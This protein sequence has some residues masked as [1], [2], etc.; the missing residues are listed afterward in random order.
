MCKQIIIIIII[1]NFQV[2]FSFI[3][4]F[5]RIFT[6]DQEWGKVVIVCIL[7]IYFFLVYS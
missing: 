2:Y 6:Q 4:I 1:S 5:H 3:T 7:Y